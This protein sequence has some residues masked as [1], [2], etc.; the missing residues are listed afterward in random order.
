MRVSLGWGIFTKSEKAHQMTALRLMY[1]TSTRNREWR[2]HREWE[3]LAKKALSVGVS[4]RLVATIFQIHVILYRIIQFP[5]SFDL[6]V[7][8]S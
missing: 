1:K 8:T 7:S 6:T 5:V 3:N 2:Q 4:L